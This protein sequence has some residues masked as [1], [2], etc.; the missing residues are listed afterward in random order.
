MRNAMK[1]TGAMGQGVGGVGGRNIKIIIK[2][3]KC[4]LFKIIIILNYNSF[5]INS[6]NF[7]HD[8]HFVKEYR[9]RF[10]NNLILVIR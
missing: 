9:Q 1:G 10:N 4:E 3:I 2:Y 6:S 7:H 8:F 5:N